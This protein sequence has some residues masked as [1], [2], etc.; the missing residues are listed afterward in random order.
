MTT[1]EIGKLAAKDNNLSDNAPSPASNSN[2]TS[3]S[4]Y[5][6]QNTILPYKLFL[7]ENIKSFNLLQNEENSENELEN[8]LKVKQNFD[9]P[10]LEI[11]VK[12]TSDYDINQ[13]KR[14]S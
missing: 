13:I 10:I 12:V 3:F 6:D 14:I 2:P 1:T 9:T 4:N 11:I 5:L 7:N 8:S